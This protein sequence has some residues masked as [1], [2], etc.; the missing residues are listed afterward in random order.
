MAD[1]LH[2]SRNGRPMRSRLPPRVKFFAVDGNPSAEGLILLTTLY[3]VIFLILN[4]HFGVQWDEYHPKGV[5]SFTS[6]AGMIPAAKLGLFNLSGIDLIV[7]YFTIS[8]LSGRFG[9]TSSPK[10]KWISAQH[11]LTLFKYQ[12]AFTP[13][14]S[15]Q[16]IVREAAVLPWSKEGSR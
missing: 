16:Q 11:L 5:S 9:R 6:E 13:L 14:S 2:Y 3:V 10:P 8:A 12:A 15:S 4:D 7:E 1:Y